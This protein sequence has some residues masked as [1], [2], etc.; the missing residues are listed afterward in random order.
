M[1]SSLI[2]LPFWYLANSTDYEAPCFLIIFGLLPPPPCYVETLPSTSC[3]RKASAH[4]VNC[5]MTPS[6]LAGWCRYI[7]EWI[8]VKYVPPTHSYPH[9]GLHS[10]VTQRWQ[11]ELWAPRKPQ[12]TRVQ[13]TCHCVVPLLL[14]TEAGLWGRVLLIRILVVAAFFIVN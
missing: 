12:T 5:R 11:Q 4:I 14:L 9:T 1:L 3:S 13:F 7:G 8:C 10:V 6:S 2:W